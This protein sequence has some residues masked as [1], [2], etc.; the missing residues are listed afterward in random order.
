MAVVDLL[1]L[2]GRLAPP[3]L[4]PAKTASAVA[5]RRGQGRPN[6]RRAVR[7]SLDGDEHGR[8]V[9]VVGSSARTSRA[10][11]AAAV[12]LSTV[13]ILPL[14][15]PKT[16]SAQVVDF[17]RPHFAADIAEA[18][19]RSGLPE[20]WIKAVAWVE[21][22]GSSRAVSPKGAMGVMQIMPGTWRELRDDLSL[23]SDPFDRR[24]NLVAGAIYLRRMLDHFGVEGFL[25]AYNAG[26]ARYQ[27]YL[28][29]RRNLPAETVAYV[30][31]VR[32]RM[33]R[34]APAVRP[35]R[36]ATAADWR[37]SDLFIGATSASPPP[38]D[39]QGDPAIFAGGAR[40]IS[41]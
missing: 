12:L 24:D 26:P 29:G 2:F 1:S 4:V 15:A 34:E 3:F 32:S 11:R 38:L 35:E 20:T 9:V 40:E 25:A 17:E 19:R 10:T 27:A 23:G 21:S 8:T 14:V 7:A 5:R 30:G 28:A 31:R 41:W 33:G 18:S 36:A 13:F 16:A 22:A 37:T 39:R 6:G